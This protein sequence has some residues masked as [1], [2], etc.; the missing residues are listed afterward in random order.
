MCLKETFRT[1]EGAN[2]DAKYFSNIKVIVNIVKKD[3]ETTSDI[4]NVTLLPTKYTNLL[5]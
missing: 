1:F 2:E 4:M 3:Y 5:A